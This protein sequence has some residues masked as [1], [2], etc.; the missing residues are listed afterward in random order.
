MD[1]PGRYKS[2]P[3]IADFIKA[4]ARAAGLNDSEAYA[5]QL[6]VDE[7]CSNIIDHAYEG[8]NEGEIRITCESRDEGLKIILKDQGKPFDP[9]KIPNPKT[10]SPVGKLRSRGAGLFLIRKM[11]DEVEF[12][13]KDGKGNVLTMV[14]KKGD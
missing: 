5:V 13:F 7:A 2:L 10:D 11:M 6:A 4:S 8:E 1:F 3:E 9:E 12:E 14:K